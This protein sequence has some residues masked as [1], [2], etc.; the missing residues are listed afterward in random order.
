MSTSLVSSPFYI[1]FPLFAQQIGSPLHGFIG[2]TRFDQY[3]EIRVFYFM[4]PTFSGYYTIIITVLPD[5]LLARDINRVSINRMSMSGD[6]RVNQKKCDE[7]FIIS[8]ICGAFYTK[9]RSSLFPDRKKSDKT[10]GVFRNLVNRQLDHMIRYNEGAFKTAYGEK[11]NNE[12]IL[13]AIVMNQ[14]DTAEIN[15]LK[16]SSLSVS[17]GFDPKKFQRLLNKIKQNDLAMVDLEDHTPSSTV[18]YISTP[19]NG[20][21][22][23]PQRK[24]D[25]SVAS[26]TASVES[27][28]KKRV[29]EKTAYASGYATRSSGQ[30]SH[31]SSGSKKKKAGG[32]KS[33]SKK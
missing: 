32:R 10:N 22:V 7:L 1:E 18:Q 15:R 33:R 25:Y 12:S 3:G 8:E 17:A 13:S 19:A 9:N 30:S 11:V 6:H 27:P 2:N 26:I 21:E 31:S 20:F 24:P 5:G 29:R 23:V 28:S 4:I 14:Y 16:D